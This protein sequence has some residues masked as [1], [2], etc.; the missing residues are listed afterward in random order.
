[1]KKVNLATPTLTFGIRLNF[2]LKCLISSS[3]SFNDQYG[4]EKCL[5]SKA[6][7][8]RQERTDGRH[9][10]GKFEVY[11]TDTHHIISL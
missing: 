4:K 11:L 7:E 8:R 6:E 9:K 1:M 3:G 5:V 10:H 2:G